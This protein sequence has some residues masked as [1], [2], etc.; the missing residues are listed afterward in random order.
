M[1]TTAE[2]LTA[3]RRAMAQ[4][5]LAAYLVPTDDFHASEYVGDYFKARE[6]LS[7][8]T[9]SAGTLLILPS[10][11]LLW[12]DGR[13]FLQAES[14]LAG[15]G[16]ELM[17]SGE[18]DVP[19]LERF[20]LAE[21]EDGSLLGFDARTVNTALARQLGNKLRAKHI[22]FAGDEDLVGAL[23]PDR[24]PLPH[25]RGGERR[26]VG[27]ERIDKVF[28]PCKADMLCAQLIPEPPRKRGVDRAGIEAEQAP[29]LQLRE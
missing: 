9:G 22:R 28:V 8:F 29:V 10:R 24:P 12:T 11:A 5:G 26:A 6:Y 2:K 4:R 1:M 19:T 7:G 16:I 14:Q 3:L 27:P 25:R 13:Y 21:L 20:L 18:P 17:R 23:W 15:S